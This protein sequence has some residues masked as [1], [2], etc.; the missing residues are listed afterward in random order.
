[1]TSLPILLFLCYY[2]EIDAK[3]ALVIANKLFT[4]NR[5]LDDILEQT[6]VLNLYSSH[7]HMCELII[8]KI[9]Y[10]QVGE[11]VKFDGHLL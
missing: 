1:M 6:D 4:I 11:A 2:I 8:M 10:F 9:Q 3:Q 7:L 5:W